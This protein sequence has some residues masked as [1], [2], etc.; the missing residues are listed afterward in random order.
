LAQLLK[1]LDEL[2]RLVNVL[3]GLMSLVGPR[4][5]HPSEL[6]RYSDYAQERLSVKPDTVTSLT[7]SMD[8]S[9]HQRLLLA[10]MRST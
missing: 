9:K 4:M 5:I 6:P 3:V 10:L 2:P 7:N 8:P 1:K